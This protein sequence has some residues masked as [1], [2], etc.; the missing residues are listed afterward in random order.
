MVSIV[1]VSALRWLFI[2]ASSLTVKLPP[3]RSVS[4]VLHTVL[5][6]LEPASA[7]ICRVDSA[8]VSVLYTGGC[9]LLWV[10]ANA[11]R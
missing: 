2:Y 6:R 9:G 7:L 4:K 10:I 1:E 5:S 8:L 3:K 11:C